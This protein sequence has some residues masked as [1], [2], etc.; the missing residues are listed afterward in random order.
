MAVY[1]L[2]AVLVIGAASFF[3]VQRA[4]GGSDIRSNMTLVAPAGPGGGWDTFQ[5]EMQQAMRANKLVNNVQVVNVPGAAGTIGLG[6]MTTMGGRANNLMV[7]GT[8]LVAGVE[9]LGAPVNHDDVTLIARVVEEYNV[10]VVK[11][12]SP[13]Q[14]LDELVTAWKA[15]PKSIAWTGGGSFDQ[16]VMTEFGTKL[17]I[18]ADQLTY[19]P[20][21]GGGEAAQALITDTAAASAAGIA[22]MTD[23]IE[24]GRLRAL[25]IA[26]PERLPGMDVPTLKEQGY[27]VTLAN[28]RA[29]VAPPG[30]TPEEKAELTTLVTEATQTPQWRDAI[31][32]NRWTDVFL[33]GPELDT[34]MK[35]EVERIGKLVEVFK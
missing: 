2:F 25:G 24:A 28:W 23:Q 30:I 14:T 27:D 20:K 33:T 8:G 12:D 18:P 3:S 31:E 32:R 17:G 7:T 9:Q 5:R 19:I 26:A 22:D 6:K 11:G 29:V 10:V 35:G 4:S 21:A 16:L 1:A 15:N 13:Y 34:W